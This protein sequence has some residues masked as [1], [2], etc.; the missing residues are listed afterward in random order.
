MPFGASAFLSGA[1]RKLMACAMVVALALP[2]PGPAGEARAQSAG[3]YKAEAVHAGFLFNFI[4]FT[5][6]PAQALAVNAPFVIGVAGN[7]ALEDELLRLADKQTVRDRRV[8]VIRVNNV[9]DL[10]GCHV[11]YIGAARQPGDEAV[12]GADELLPGVRN[13]PVLTVSESPSF[14]A[15]GGI[16]NLYVAEG[17]KLRFE[18]SIDNAKASGLTLSSRLLALA[19]I[20]NGPAAERAPGS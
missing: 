4:R 3:A 9:R 20:V 17:A 19:R 11:L 7:R 1:R 13:R 15:Q 18:I 16:I 6:W 12:P 10:A 5:D 8:R 2:A 14:L